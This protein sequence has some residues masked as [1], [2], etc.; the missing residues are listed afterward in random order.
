MRGLSR[1]LF[2]EAFWP[3][4]FFIGALT[5]IVWLSQ[6][7]RFFG[8]LIDQQ[9][10]AGTFFFLIGL[11]IPSILVFVLPGALA[12]AAFYALFRLHADSELVVMSSA[13]ISRLRIAAPFLALA[14]LV[15]GG[16]WAINLYV[17]P[18]AQ[19]TLRD[20]IFEIRGDIISNVLRPGQFTVAGSGLTVYVRERAGPRRALGILLHDSREAE[21]PITY[22]AETGDIADTDEGPRF[23]LTNGTVQ[24][25][26][27]EGRV[28]TLRF[29]R[30]VIDLAPFQAEARGADRGTPER[31]L[32]ELFNPPNPETLTETRRNDMFAEAHD[33]LSSP[34]YSF[35][36]VLLPVAAI[37]TA[38]SGRRSLGWR[39]AAAA[40]ALIVIRVMGLGLRGFTANGPMLW[41]ILYLF[42]AGVAAGLF[43]WL[44]DLL[45]RFSRK[46]VESETP[47]AQGETA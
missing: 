32:G 4:L 9:Q 33:R 29:E 11:I 13:G 15:A 46:P 24:R 28:A 30:Y 7:L 36:I 2:A 35:L 38:T 10:S 27:G 31:Y 45:P 42:P 22:T 14:A 3:L 6:S 47:P 37:A 40:G 34:L 44:G 12:C 23:I 26:E 25:V 39:L 17:N 43:L 8:V 21:R 19:R 41:P 18:L 1:Y 16:Q 20:L 5:G